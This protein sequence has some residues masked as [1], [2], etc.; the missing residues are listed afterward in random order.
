MSAVPVNIYEVYGSEFVKGQSLVAENQEEAGMGF[1]FPGLDIMW[2]DL[3]DNHIQS[4]SAMEN[5]NEGIFTLNMSDGILCFD[6]SGKILTFGNYNGISGFSDGAAKVY[7]YLPRDPN[8]TGRLLAPPDQEEGFIDREGNEIIPLGKLSGLGDKFSEGLAVIGGYEENKGYID[9]SSEI[10]IPMVYKNAGQFSGGMAPVQSTDTEL[11]GYI[12]KENKIVIPMSYEEAKPFSEG[13]AYVVKGGKAGYIDGIGNI[14]IDYKFMPE[15]NKYRDNSFHGGMAVVR[16]SSGKYGYINRDGNF[17]IP[18]IYLDADPF[19][20]DTAFVVSENQNY[21]NGYGSSFLINGKGERLT[22][23]WQYGHYSGDYVSDGLMRALSSYGPSRNEYVV[24]LNK[25]GAEVIPSSLH[26]E[27]LSQFNQGYALLIAHSNDK[28]AVGLVKKPENI[29][30]YTAGKLVRVFMNGTLIDFT[31]TDPVIE[32]SRTLVPMR[33]VFEAL[34]AEITW[35]EANKT[36][37]GKKGEITVSLKIDDNTGYINNEP[38]KL[39]VPA[40]IKNSR[41]IVPLRFIAESFN[42]KVDWDAETRTVKITTK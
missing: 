27:N 11:W 16:D 15:D 23:L 28:T 24:M 25:Y 39:D 3:K 41:T 40:K 31:D 4:Y 22:P 32:D 34:G 13:L 9:K 8:Y 18:A 37:S 30:A 6:T 20:G 17:A 26:I 42:A 35:D 5:F 14:V 21:L 10:V 29:E 36:V 19:I 2:L 7:K 12:D 1:S 38:V 33:A